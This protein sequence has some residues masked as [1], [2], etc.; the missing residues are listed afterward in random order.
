MSERTEIDARMAV[1][2]DK[3]MDQK[4]SE[5]REGGLTDQMTVTM[6]DKDP[7][8]STPCKGENKEVGLSE[9]GSSPTGSFQSLQSSQSSEGGSG[10]SISP[11][12][13]ENRVLKFEDTLS[14]EDCQN[15]K[16]I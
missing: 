7:V 8:G 2:E 14:K 1:T 11:L 4:V 5:L 13:R 12:V 9:L 15:F 16:L 6:N 3:E 10:T